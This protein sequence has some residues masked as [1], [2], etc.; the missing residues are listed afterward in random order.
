MR[1]FKLFAGLLS[2]GALTVA[3]SQPA[4]AQAQQVQQEVIGNVIQGIIQNTRDEVQRRR[5]APP[6]GVL[7]FSGESSDFNG[8]DLF[9]EQSIENPF[10]ALAY[11]KAPALVA[12]TPTWLYGANLVG[13]AD[14]ATAAFG[15]GVNL[16]TVVGAFDVTK[17][18]VFGATD[19]L[20]FIGTGGN[21]W[22]RAT[23][24]FGPAIEDSIP[25]TSATISYMNG[26]FSIDASILA[27]WGQSWS[28]LGYTLNTQYRF[29]LPYSVWFEPTVGVTYAEGYSANFG[30]KM[31][32]TTEVHGGARLGTEMMWMG[33]KVQPTVS[34]I[35]FGIVNQDLYGIRGSAKMNV[36]WAKNFSS[37][38]EVHGT[39][40]TASAPAAVVVVPGLGVVPIAGAAVQTVGVQAGLR[41]TWN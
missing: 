6:A 27:S 10:G 15:T 30:T 32:D 7:R 20:T 23:T 40:A 38:L 39:A 36:I 17:I 34:A 5:L 31:G 13:S 19:A 18:G 35:A 37:Y 29:D 8:R 21:T 24:P 12:A 2:A 26:G 4:A 1:S 28:G 11:A 14:H 16:Q 9:A 3:L 41:Y 33:Y 25:S 22:S